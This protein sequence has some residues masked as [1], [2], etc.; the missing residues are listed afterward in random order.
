MWRAML[1]LGR[2][3]EGRGC[4]AKLRTDERDGGRPTSDVSRGAGRGLWPLSTLG[5]PSIIC[6]DSNHQ[7]EGGII[8]A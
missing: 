4:R 1:D 7:P 2:E 5:F 6:L 3:F 8:E